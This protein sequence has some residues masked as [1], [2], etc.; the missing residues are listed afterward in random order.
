MAIQRGP[1]IVT[2]G[3]V[4]AVDSANRNCYVSGSKSCFDISVTNITGSLKNGT[5]FNSNNIGSFVFDGTNDYINLGN[6][7]LGLD[8]TDKSFCLWIYLASSFVNAAGLIDK[9]FDNTAPNYGGW[10]FWLQTNRKLWWWNHANL[11]LLDDGPN[12]VPLTKWTFVSVTY[13][14]TSKTANFYIN[15]NLNSSKTNASIVEK[16]SSTTNLILAATRNASGAFLNGRISNV[17]AYNR[18]LSATEITQ[19]F[20][21]TRARFGI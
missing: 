7:N 12:V 2:S 19:I 4:F 15:A 1:K 6:N 17:T 18:V 5:G 21:T 9:D 14:S 3:L 10:G 13:N 20:N 8:L 11:D 16:S